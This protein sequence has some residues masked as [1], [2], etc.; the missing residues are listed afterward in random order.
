MHKIQQ[1]LLR[2]AKLHAEFH[3]YALCFSNNHPRGRDK[4]DDIKETEEKHAED[5][6]YDTFYRMQR[7]DKSNEKQLP[8]KDVQFNLG[9]RRFCR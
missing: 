7:Y 3:I 4:I 8:T 6:M 5:A 2:W 9:Q 1:K